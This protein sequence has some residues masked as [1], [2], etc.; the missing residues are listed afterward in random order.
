MMKGKGRELSGFVAAVWLLAAPLA[1]AAPPAPKPPRTDCILVAHAGSQDRPV[2]SVRMCPA[3]KAKRDFQSSLENKWG[4]LFDAAT[5]ARVREVVLHEKGQPPTPAGIL[6]PGTFS[7][8]W[9]DKGKVE[10]DSYTLEPAKSCSFLDELAHAVPAKDDAEFVRVLAD[11]QARV[12]CPP[13]SA[14]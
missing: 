2:G 5:F 12:H 6:P 8:S 14:K 1:S 9:R 13:V 3:R 4:F 11:L 10:D 7:V